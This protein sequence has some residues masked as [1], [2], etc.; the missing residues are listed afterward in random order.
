MATLSAAPAEPAF[1]PASGPAPFTKYLAA[2]LEK[3][4]LNIEAVFDEARRAVIKDTTD[5]QQPFPRSNI[6]ETFYFHDPLPIKAELPPGV[7]KRNRKDRQE[8]V[9]ILPGKFLMGCVPND[10][11]C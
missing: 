11:K 3:P 1:Y 5:R 2:A 8:Y 10:S 7:P 6:T 4:G 9:W